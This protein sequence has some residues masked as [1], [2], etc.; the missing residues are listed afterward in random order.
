MNSF[1]MNSIVKD[2]LWKEKQNNFIYP[3][4]TVNKIATPII[5]DSASSE[6]YFIMTAQ[7]NLNDAILLNQYAG[8]ELRKLSKD[9]KLL[10]ILKNKYGIEDLDPYN[11][12]LEKAA[13]TAK[14]KPVSNPLNPAATKTTDDQT[15]VDPKVNDNAKK[16]AEQKQNIFIRMW[17]TIKT[18]FKKIVAAT[19]NFVKAVIAKVDNGI[20]NMESKWMMEH[21]DEYDNIVK[22]A[23]QRNIVC[24]VMLPRSATSKSAAN[25]GGDVALEKTKKGGST[26]AMREAHTSGIAGNLLTILGNVEKSFNGYNELNNK[27]SAALNEASG[28]LR[29][30]DNNNIFQKA[31][32]A[33]KTIMAKLQ[34]NVINEANKG[35]YIEIFSFG[36]PKAKAF[37]GKNFGNTK[38]VNA[39]NIVNVIFYGDISP[40]TEAKNIADYYGQ[41]GGKDGVSSFMGGEMVT[42]FS[43]LKVAA[44]NM[45]KKLNETL[46][47]CDKN[48]DIQKLLEKFKD[49][50]D[51]PKI[52]KPTSEDIATF[53]NCVRYLQNND[54]ILMGILMGLYTEI[55]KHR[56]WVIYG[57][58][59]GLKAIGIKKGD[60][61]N[62]HSEDEEEEE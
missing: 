6:E 28:Y 8:N 30:L 41:L 4:L 40:K 37:I 3:S 26:A 50:K 18:A 39:R 45:M 10:S 11:F 46:K 53:N 43:G 17:M 32:A 13:S 54:N 7:E 15:T 52:V 25:P 34:P 60:A 22:A 20:M 38:T 1:N 9:V 23:K 36:D 55:L 42:R 44:Q 2:S 12:S 5:L 48:D 57:F 59:Q 35:M 24:K 33:G 62:D 31:A 27:I 58:K 21:I 29:S 51:F 16:A 47:G 49:N 14:A 56:S 19:T 61:A